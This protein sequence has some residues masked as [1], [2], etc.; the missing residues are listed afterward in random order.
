MTPIWAW[1][2]RELRRHRRR[3]RSR[4]CCSSASSGAVVLTTAAGARRTGIGLRALRR[5]RATPPTSAAVLHRGRTSTT[6]CS[7]RLPRRPRRSSGAS[8]LYSPS[9]SPRA[10]DYDLGVFAGPTRRCSARSTCRASSRGAGPIPSNPHEVLINRFTQEVLGV[11]VGDTVT[12][13]HLRRRAV[14][15]RRGRLRGAGWARR[16]RS[17]STASAITP[18]DLADPEFTPGSTARRR[19]TRRTGARRAASA[20][21][22]RWRR[23]RA[24]IPAAIVERAIADFELDEVFVSRES[25]AD[26]EG[27][28]RHHASSRS[29]CAA[30]AAVAGLA[31]LVAGAQALHRRMAETADDLPALRAHG[32]RPAAQCTSA[33]MAVGAPDRRWSASRW[34]SSSRSSGSL[35]MPIGIA[36]TAEPS[37][38]LDVDVLALG[39]GALLL[40]ALLGGQRRCSARCTRLVPGWPGRWPCAPVDPP[41]SLLASGRFSPSE[42]ARGHDGARS[43]RGAHLG[44]RPLRAS[45]ARRSA[46]PASSP[47]SPSAP[48]STPSS[49]TRRQRLELD[50][51]AR[52]RPTRTSS[53]LARRRRG[54]GRRDASGSARC[55]PRSSG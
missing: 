41:P 18:Y 2:R 6:R 26:R 1:A 42:P 3:R 4:S 22:S 46:S 24:R 29:G 25:R 55:R 9:R 54:R 38:G 7:T 44:P 15:R 10:R 20:P 14:R 35:A 28:G 52:R 16:S 45:S 50:V 33:V 34:R 51:R 48:A 17:R 12:R 32:L 49:R 5:G 23:H 8:P 11:E 53:T 43:G 30:F 13:R 40:V 31:A 27:R 21:R 37:P 36:R 47:R 19:S 39:L